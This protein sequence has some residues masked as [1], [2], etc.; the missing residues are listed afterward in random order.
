MSSSAGVATLNAP[1]GGG[2]SPASYSS[3]RRF[4]GS[5]KMSRGRMG[6]PVAISVSDYEGARELTNL[7]A[8]AR[9]L[10]PDLVERVVDGD[11]SWASFEAKRTGT[12][13]RA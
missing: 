3:R 5:A 10:I 9:S 4:P 11:A 2:A 1:S 7:S 13:G 8:F 6:M 12:A